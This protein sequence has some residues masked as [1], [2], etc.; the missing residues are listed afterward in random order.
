MSDDSKDVMRDTW[1]R[2]LGYSNEVGESFRAIAPV[3]L[4]RASYGL[5][6][7]YV[8]ADTADKGV[9]M[10]MKDGRPRNVMIATGDALIWQTLASIVIPGITINRICAYSGRALSK[11]PKIP[12]AVRTWMTVGIG[13]ASIPFIVVPIDIG[14]TFLM[15]LTYRR[16][17]PTDD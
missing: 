17:V 1:A 8:L 9:R 16:W 5:A 4:V 6:F 12:G 2:Y 10:L 11:Y 3:K 14:V 13:L 7:A 15:N